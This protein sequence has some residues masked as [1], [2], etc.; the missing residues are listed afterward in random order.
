MA[1][2][3][4]PRTSRSLTGPVDAWS[5]APPRYLNLGLSARA[6]LWEMLLQDL[7]SVCCANFTSA[8]GNSG[9]CTREEGHSGGQGAV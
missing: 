3:E 7:Q 5:L 1:T 4:D 8:A 6:P 9:L 2:R